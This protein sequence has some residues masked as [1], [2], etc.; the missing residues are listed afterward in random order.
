MGVKLH[1]V[2]QVSW[3]AKAENLEFYH[4]KQDYIKKPKRP[5]KPRK[6]KYKSIESFE[7]QMMEQEAAICHEKEVKVKGNSM[8]QKYYVERLLPIYI[9]AIKFHCQ[10]NPSQADS[11]EL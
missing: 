7:H 8:T 9:N 2:A 10:M 5:C 3:E 1:V 4:D 11:Y 6:H